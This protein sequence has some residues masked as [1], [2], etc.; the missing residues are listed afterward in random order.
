MKKLAIVLVVIV[1]FVVAASFAKDMLVKAAVTGG[2]RTVTG[3][4]L[5]I[6]GMHVGLDSVQIRDLLLSNPAGYQDRTMVDM[7]EFYV[8]YQLLT[9]FGGEP[10]INV[11]RLNLK[12]IIIVKNRGGELNLDSLKVVKQK[13]EAAKEPQKK[14]APAPKVRIDLLELKIGRVIYKDYSRGS[15]PQVREFNLNIDEKYENVANTSEIASLIITKALLNTGLS[16]ITGFDVGIFQGDL[17]SVSQTATQAA[18]Q[19]TG[20]ATEAAK[21]TAETLKSMLPFGN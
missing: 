15:Q 7:P 8:R 3:L 14:A 18:N 4:D 1:A 21:K 17:S 16:S 13:K 6:K 5:A 19:V 2:F 11:L 12:D 10:H 20:T 9:L